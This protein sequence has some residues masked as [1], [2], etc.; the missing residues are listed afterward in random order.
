MHPEPRSGMTSSP[1]DPG[2]HRAASDAQKNYR[3]SPGILRCLSDASCPPCGTENTPF[4]LESFRPTAELSLSTPVTSLE[5]RQD[6]GL[7]AAQEVTRTTS[8]TPE[9]VLSRPEPPS[10]TACL[11]LVMESPGH[12]SEYFQGTPDPT[13]VLDRDR[14]SPSAQKLSGRPQVHL[15]S[16]HA[17]LAYQKRPKAAEIVWRASY[18]LLRPPWPHLSSQR[19]QDQSRCFLVN[20]MSPLHPRTPQGTSWNR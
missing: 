13:G 20:P 2:S 19:T 7:P 14:E 3:A 15:V 12:A 6:L 8:G 9:I 18:M 17:A 16:F 5:P 4:I 10:M 11:P 1:G